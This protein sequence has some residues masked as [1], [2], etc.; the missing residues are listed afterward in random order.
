MI[1]FRLFYEEIDRNQFNSYT[2]SDFLDIQDR[3]L[4]KK[5]N[6]IEPNISIKDWNNLQIKELKEFIR[7][8]MS[9]YKDIN[10]NEM[11]VFISKLSKS[12]PD[13]FMKLRLRLA[14]KYPSLFDYKTGL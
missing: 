4:D 1:S 5:Y 6:S 3:D 13:F 10:D 14:A 12:Y 2:G 11:S 8:K 9:T 7:S